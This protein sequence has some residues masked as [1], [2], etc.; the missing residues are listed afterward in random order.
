MTIRV[1]LKP[2]VEARVKEEASAQGLTVEEF[3][4]TVI[5]GTLKTG[6]E[7]TRLLTMKEAMSDELFLAD[8]KELAEG[9]ENLPPYTGNYSREDIYFD[10]D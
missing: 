6:E 4:A 9:T 5:E 2:E 10:H 7:D 1:E 8:M 3:L